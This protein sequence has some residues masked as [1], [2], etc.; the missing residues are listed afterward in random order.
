MASSTRD[1][2]VDILGCPA[3]PWSNNSCW[4][5]S[6]LQLLFVAF[7]SLGMGDLESICINL[8]QDSI[9]RSTVYLA[10]ASRLRG[11]HNATNP[12]ISGALAAQRDAVR[13]TL[14]EIGLAENLSDSPF[15]SID[16]DSIC[17]L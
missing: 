6:G 11:A 2:I 14:R 5:D 12:N 7:S 8:S 10:I 9:I 13:E 4:L 3:Y 15:V 17:G 1:T 16:A